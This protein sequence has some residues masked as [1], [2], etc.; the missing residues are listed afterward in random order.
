MRRGKTKEEQS[1]VLK[2]EEKK[3]KNRGI[4]RAE[5]EGVKQRGVTE[6]ERKEKSR[7][8]QRAGRGAKTRAEL[9]PCSG[10]VKSD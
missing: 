9:E 2:K 7:E 10:T 4:W 1:G 8:L 5:L 6:V 3:K